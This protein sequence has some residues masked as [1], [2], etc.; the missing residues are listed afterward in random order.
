MERSN[1]AL[2]ISVAVAVLIGVVLVGI[3]SQQTVDKTQKVNAASEAVAMNVTGFP[4]INEDQVYTVAE[5]PTGWK[6]DSCPLTNFV[7]AN[8]TGTELTL[9]TDYTVDL[10]AGTY[11]LVDNDDTNTTYAL[12][13]TNNTYVSYTYCPDD[14]VGGWAGTVA[15]LV[16]GFFV[17]GILLG[18]VFVIFFVLRNEG[19]EFNI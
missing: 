12:Y 15:N 13:P 19:V 18:V 5:N 14:Y 10:S 17:L 1:V 16:P 7:V 4:A 3:V 11:S 2:V 6:A 8:A 9:T